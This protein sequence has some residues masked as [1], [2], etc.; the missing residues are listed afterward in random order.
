[1]IVITRRLAKRLKTVFRQA[2][3]L[4]GRSEKPVVQLTAGSGGLRIRCG[5]GR[6]F[7][8][9]H[10]DGD[11][12]KQTVFV[13]FDLLS[14]V[15]GNRN[16]PVEIRLHE[17][18]VSATWRDGAVPKAVQHDHPKI[19]AEDWPSTPNRMIGNPPHLLSAL[20]DAAETTDPDSARYSLGCIQL[21][22]TTGRLVATDGRQLLV[23]RGYTFP[24]KDDL[25]LP[26]N[27]LFGSAQLPDDEP[28]HVGHVE[29]YFV[30]RLGP[31]TFWLSLHTDGRFPDA[32]SHVGRSESAVAS[33]EVAA[34]D[35]RFLL[36]N[37]VQLPG[38]DEY[39]LPV[40]M[41][42]NGHV[43][44]RA[45]SAEQPH[46]TELLLS[47]SQYAGEPVRLNMNRCYLKRAIELGFRQGHVFGPKAPMLC[48]DD[49]RSYLW[50][51]LDPESAVPPDQDAIRIQSPKPEA[52]LQVPQT[53]THNRKVIMPDSK[54]S[55]DG[56]AKSVGRRKRVNGKAP[57][58]N[59]T[60]LIEQAEA[61]K[62]SLRESLT[63]TSQ[64]VSALKQHRKRSKAVRT[65]LA[66]LRELQPTGEP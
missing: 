63:K 65:A 48:Q 29:E 53:K 58:D 10:L 1:M 11:Q 9:F 61:V 56:H 6:A 7:A 2:L 41:D 59:A 23:Q 49:R 4:S 37:V 21:R 5:N 51:L 57:H 40:T 33:F 54:P 31:W 64:L 16:I 60:A 66:S 25:L 8:E 17:G 3:N 30:M 18:K 20:R 45:T 44:L 35:A 38:D 32:E 46:P 22:G 52:E 26:T 15:S 24:W 28:V 14:D 42:F 55:E 47:E 36:E 39:N 62:V 50:A 19:L 27:K 34:S 12:P 13:P 43:A